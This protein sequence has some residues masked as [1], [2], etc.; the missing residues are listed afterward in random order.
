[1]TGLAGEARSKKKKKQWVGGASQK[2]WETRTKCP[3]IEEQTRLNALA[4]T[5]KGK[6]TPYEILLESQGGG[7]P[8]VTKNSKGGP[9]IFKK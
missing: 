5:G 4:K 6:S 2:G 9:S 3:F 7:G 8:T 1:L